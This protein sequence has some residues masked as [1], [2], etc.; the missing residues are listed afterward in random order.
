MKH[1][2]IVCIVLIVVLLRAIKEQAIKKTIY[3]ELLFKMMAI[4]QWLGD[5]FNIF[6]STSD[7]KYSCSGLSIYYRLSKV[8]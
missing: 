8:G 1:Y 6:Q 3:F 2:F 7:L 5:R 4:Q